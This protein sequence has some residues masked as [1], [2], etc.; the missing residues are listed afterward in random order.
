MVPLQFSRWTE[1]NAV[2]E[3]RASAASAIVWTDGKVTPASVRPAMSPASHPVVRKYALVMDTAIVDTAGSLSFRY[4]CQ[5][6]LPT[7]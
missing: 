6:L 4:L 1:L 2:A 3:A 7:I 5:S